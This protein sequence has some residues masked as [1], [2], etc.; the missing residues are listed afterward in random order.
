MVS[1]CIQ[2]EVRA[3]LL[4]LS[5]LLQ[6]SYDEGPETQEKLACR[7]PLTS[8]CAVGFHSYFIICILISFYF[9]ASRILLSACYYF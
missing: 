6:L 4:L 9:A 3:C 8:T 1:T 2:D 7:A 5:P